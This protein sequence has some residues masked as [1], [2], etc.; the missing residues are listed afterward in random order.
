[1]YPSPLLSGSSSRRV[2]SCMLRCRLTMLMYRWLLHLCKCI[3]IRRDAQLLCNLTSVLVCH[4]CMY[5]LAAALT[6][7]LVGRSR[8]IAWSMHYCPLQVPDL[9]P[10]FK[11]KV[12]AGLAAH[13]CFRRALP[14]PLA[15]LRILLLDFPRRVLHAKTGLQCSLIRSADTASLLYRG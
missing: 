15:L 10:S 7:S 3:R 5:L 1:M 11:C 6:R 13:C 2:R 4:V 9:T 8:N 14:F 12:A